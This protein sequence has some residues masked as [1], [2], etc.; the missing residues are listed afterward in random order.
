MEWFDKI[1]ATN[2]PVNST[3]GQ[4]I[5]TIMPDSVVKGLSIARIILN[6]TANLA[7]AGNGGNLT[8]GILKMTA[9]AVAA[10]VFPN[11]EDEADKPGWLFRRREVVFAS[12]S[13]DY[14]Q[15]NK[16]DVDLHTGRKYAGE[17][18]LL[19]LVMNYTGLTESVNVNGLI[20]VLGRKP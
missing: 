19:V 20:R 2:V 12:I 18:Q 5:D 10:L 14:S 3:V 4:A 15:V 11:P 1:I 7:T 6:L 8:L 13:N 9:D 17:D 16:I